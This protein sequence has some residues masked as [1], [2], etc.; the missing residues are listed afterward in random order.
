MAPSDILKKCDEKNK[1]LKSI[2]NESDPALLTNLRQQY[3]H[4]KVQLSR[5]RKRPC[6][7]SEVLW[8]KLARHLL[9]HPDQHYEQQRIRPAYL[10]K[11]Y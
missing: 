3:K 6:H 1:L 7:D 8:M 9:C 10:G 2:K 11:L 4:G 5:C